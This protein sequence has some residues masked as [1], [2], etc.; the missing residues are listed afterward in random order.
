VLHKAGLLVGYCPIAILPAWY[1]SHHDCLSLVP[2]GSRLLDCHA[3]SGPSM[4]VRTDSAIRALV[5]HLMI[6]PRQASS[7]LGQVGTSSALMARPVRLALPSHCTDTYS[8]Y[9]RPYVQ[10]TQPT[11]PTA[12]ATWRQ[13]ALALHGPI[14]HGHD[15]ALAVILG[16]LGACGP[17]QAGD[18]AIRLGFVRP[19]CFFLQQS[20]LEGNGPPSIV[21]LKNKVVTSRE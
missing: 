2:L 13:P 9:L 16:I 17:S 10:G 4:Q 6:G 5:Q 20:C 3:G 11:Y 19:A 1:A 7:T 15:A 12:P 18:W 21:R 8:T 14:A